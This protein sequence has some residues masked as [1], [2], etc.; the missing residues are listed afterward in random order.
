MY[1]SEN[2]AVGANGMD[3]S[4]ETTLN[5]TSTR[6]QRVRVYNTGRV[7]IA[8][9]ANTVTP[10][11]LLHLQGTDSGISITGNG[12]SL[13]ATEAIVSQS[14]I[15]GTS[16]FL[17]SNLTV[18]GTAFIS[19]VSSFTTSTGTFSRVVAASTTLNGVAYNW[20]VDDGSTGYKLTTDGAGQLSWM[21]ETTGV[22]NL[23]STQTF[24]GLN[25]FTNPVVISTSIIKSSSSAG[26]PPL[27]NALYSD[28]LIRAWAII[29]GTGTAWVPASFNVSSFLDLGTG[30]YQI[31]L[32]TPMQSIHEYG[33]GTASQYV[34]LCSM[35]RTDV[36]NNDTCGPF[37]GGTTYFG[38]NTATFNSS[39]EGGGDNDGIVFG[40][41][42][43]GKQ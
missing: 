26:S 17:S 40:V 7:A 41:I 5:G 43:G 14:S 23:G 19:S 4:L 3:L 29:V 12:V 28:N 22:V 13:Y 39:T 20:P 18:S 1:A 30:S 27:A 10:L 2:S 15:T 38:N 24:S 32:Q 21:P 9:R 25:T 37:A 36:T 35:Y 34:I 33:S 31:T 42:L 6:R 16:A 11:G 8:P